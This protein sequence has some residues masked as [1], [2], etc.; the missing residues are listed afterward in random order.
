MSLIAAGG[1]H[2]VACGKVNGA[3]TIV[4]FGSNTYGQLGTGFAGVHTNAVNG[5]VKVSDGEENLR[6]PL[7][8]SRAHTVAQVAAGNDHSAVLTKR[9][10]QH[11]LRMRGLTAHA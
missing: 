4:S 10:K 3:P 5:P 8:N 1:A 9:T 6:S 2:T 7:W 11:L